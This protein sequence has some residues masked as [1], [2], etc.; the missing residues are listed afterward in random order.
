MCVCVCDSINLSRP[1]KLKLQASYISIPQLLS[2]ASGLSDCTH[3]KNLSQLLY[4]TFLALPSDLPA[5][6]DHIAAFK[7]CFAKVDALNYT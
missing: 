7:A 4:K 2:L 6:V 5:K 1:L 3:L